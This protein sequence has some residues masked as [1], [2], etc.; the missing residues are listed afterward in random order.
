MTEET[1]NYSIILDEEHRRYLG[2]LV[3]K[4]PHMPDGTQPTA[5]GVFRVML[6]NWE[7]NMNEL[8]DL[9]E[10]VTELLETVDAEVRLKHLKDRDVSRHLTNK[11]MSPGPGK[12]GGFDF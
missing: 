5:A 12:K 2:R 8:A 9:R 1:K 6:K 11:S 3:A 10:Q 4:R 7:S